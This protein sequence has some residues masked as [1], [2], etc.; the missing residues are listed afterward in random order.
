[1]GDLESLLEKAKEV[2]SEESAKDMLDVIEGK[3]KLLDEGETG[4]YMIRGID[5]WFLSGWSGD[6]KERPEKCFLESCICVCKG[7]V[8][9]YYFN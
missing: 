2:I 4:K 1:M 8:E 5:G 3:I 7:D 6:N 9:N